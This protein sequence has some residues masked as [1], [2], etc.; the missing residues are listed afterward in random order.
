MPGVASDGDFWISRTLVTIEA[1]KRDLKHVVLLK[2]TDTDDQVICAKAQHLSSSL[3]ETV[4]ASQ[5][6]TAKGAQLLLSAA[7]LQLYSADDDNTDTEVLE[8][9]PGYRLVQRSRH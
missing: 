2:N 7:V 5:Q 9:I 3:L 6:E 8:V 4:Q 1:L